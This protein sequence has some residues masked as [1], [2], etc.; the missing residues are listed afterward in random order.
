[1]L[2]GKLVLGGRFFCSVERRVWAFLILLATF[3]RLSEFE[4]S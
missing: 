4:S 1:M 2:A 3:K